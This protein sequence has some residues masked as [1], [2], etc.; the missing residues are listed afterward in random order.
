VSRPASLTGMAE[1]GNASQSASVTSENR[2]GQASGAA[3]TPFG[4]LA[5]SE[6]PAKVA[7][8]LQNTVGSVQDRVIRPLIVAARAVVF[9]IVIAAM[10]LV[11]CVLLTIAA[12]RLLDVYAFRHRVWPAYGVVGAVLVLG[13]A[14]LWSKRS[15]PEM[16]DA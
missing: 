8:G 9:G 13:G 1:G 6:W 10:A 15:T 5:A 7:D 16:K 4:G 3:A 2:A 11:L 12:I 14:F